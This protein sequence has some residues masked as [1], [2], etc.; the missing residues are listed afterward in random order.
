MEPAWMLSRYEFY[1]FSLRGK[2]KERKN[3]QCFKEVLIMWNEHGRSQKTNT[4]SISSTIA[5]SS[6][7]CVPCSAWRNAHCH[8][9]GTLWGKQNITTL[10]LTMHIEKRYAP[11]SLKFSHADARFPGGC[12]VQHWL[13]CYVEK[14][15][16]SED[17][18][19][20]SGQFPE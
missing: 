5:Y 10:T 12:P 3:I 6:Q 17:A 18:W 4:R 2:K 7:D 1:Y 11:G 20:W 8:E 13:L 15:K 14:P 16:L 19:T 9:T